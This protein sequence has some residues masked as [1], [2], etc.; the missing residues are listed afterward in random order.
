MVVTLQQEFFYN[1]VLKGDRFETDGF[2]IR[3]CM[4]TRDETGEPCPACIKKK[5]FKEGRV[6][7]RYDTCAGM[8]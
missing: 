1:Y 3:F 2:E 5:R 8:P 6:V 7:E 4:K